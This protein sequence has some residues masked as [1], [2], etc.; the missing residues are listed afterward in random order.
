MILKLS[1]TT[2]DTYNVVGRGTGRAI[3]IPD[4]YLVEMELELS[5]ILNK[6]I[7]LDFKPFLVTGI[8]RLGEKININGCLS[9][10]GN[11]LEN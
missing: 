3:K 11:Y 1:F 8:E 5:D 10:F 6:I 7:I 9:V 4:K 2:I